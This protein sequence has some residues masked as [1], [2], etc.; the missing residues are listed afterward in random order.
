MWNWVVV[1]TFWRRWR[2][3]SV[4]KVRV[5]ETKWPLLFTLIVV[6]SCYPLQCPFPGLPA[7]GHARVFGTSVDLVWGTLLHFNQS[8]RVEFYCDEHWQLAK[9]QSAIITCLNN[10]TWSDP[11]PRCGQDNLFRLIVIIFFLILKLFPGRTWSRSLLV[12][13]SWSATRGHLSGG[14]LRLSTSARSRTSLS[15]RF[16]YFLLQMRKR[17]SIR[18]KWDDFLRPQNGK[19]E[20]PADV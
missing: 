20:F 14:L 2:L 6:G 9:N 15:Q 19:M 10:G 17:L 16:A 3:Q 8:E 18:G 11:V 12:G 1:P 4:Q 13:K 5:M 7:N